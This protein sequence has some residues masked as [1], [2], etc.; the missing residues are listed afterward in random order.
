MT[1]KLDAICIKFTKLINNFK[2]NINKTFNSYLSS[3]IA[4]FK[5]QLSKLELYK[6]DLISMDNDIRNNSDN[7]Q[8]APIEHLTNSRFTLI[9][10]KFEDLDAKLRNVSLPGNRDNSKIQQNSNTGYSE[11][12][13]H[14]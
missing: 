13:K 3:K 14:I 7:I 9:V 8:Q 10:E 12:E 6:T 11:F 2:D 5:L 1:S 4:T